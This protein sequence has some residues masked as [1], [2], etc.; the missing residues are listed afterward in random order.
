MQNTNQREFHSNSPAPSLQKVRLFAY[1]RLA[2]RAMTDLFFSLYLS[3]VIEAFYNLHIYHSK[4][5]F[6][7]VG[8]E[9]VDL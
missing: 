8:K 3:T 7:I 4:M 1:N 6:A 2:D 5:F 9:H